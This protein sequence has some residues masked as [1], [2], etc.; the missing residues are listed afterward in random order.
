MTFVYL[1]EVRTQAIFLID[2]S[3][4]VINHPFLHLGLQHVPK[5]LSTGHFTVH[6]EV[7]GTNN[8][9]ITGVCQ[10]HSVQDRY[11]RKTGGGNG[12]RASTFSAW[13]RK[14]LKRFKTEQGWKGSSYLSLHRSK[15]R[16]SQSWAHVMRDPPDGPKRRWKVQTAINNRFRS[17]WQ[18]S[19]N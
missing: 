5:T 9:V 6:E 15:S 7:K 3:S 4:S 19:E 14:P 12:Q 17:P 13:V 16:T 8:G 18:S 11:P 2:F 10:D 1:Q